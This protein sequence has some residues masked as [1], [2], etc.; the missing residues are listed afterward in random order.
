M[1]GK[2]QGDPNVTEDGEEG[3]H[4]DKNWGSQSTSTEQRDDHQQSVSAAFMQKRSF[5]RT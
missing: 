4:Q 1:A 3:K 5:K 2:A